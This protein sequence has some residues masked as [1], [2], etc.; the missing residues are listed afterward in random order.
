MKLLGAAEGA[1]PVCHPCEPPFVV[2]VHGRRVR[3]A[4]SARGSQI[5]SSLVKEITFNE[6]FGRP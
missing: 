2:V 1:R 3:A 4:A 5:Q 6:C